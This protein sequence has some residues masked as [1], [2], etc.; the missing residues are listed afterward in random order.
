MTKQLFDR[1]PEHQPILWST[2]RHEDWP[3]ARKIISALTIC[4][5]AVA[6][7]ISGTALGRF[8]FAWSDL[9]AQFTAPALILTAILAPILLLLRLKTAFGVAVVTAAALSAAVWPQWMVD[10]GRPLVGAPVITLYSANLHLENANVSKIRSSIAQ[11]KPDIVVVVEASPTVLQELDSILVNLPNR[12]TI[13]PGIA[14]A[15]R[16]PLIPAS[17]NVRYAKLYA[18]AHI[19]SPLG[20]LNVV[21]V[22]LMRPWP[23]QAQEQ[24]I[25]GVAALEV[26][27]SQVT[28][29][30]LVAGD[31]NSVS[32]GRIGRLIQRQTGLKPNPGWPGT[33]PALAPPPFAITIDQ[34]YRTPDL[35]VLKRGLGR[36]TGSDHR[37]VVTKITESAKPGVPD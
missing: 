5:M 17:H 35:A 36:D 22:H 34:V 12:M 16:Y 4:L 29:P 25:R 9:L 14:I 15:S 27:L 24:Q 30:A 13:D 23:Y 37:P 1:G 18:L 28:G 33:W 2:R 10:R 20:P 19:D 11:A 21:G 6:L 7:L 3:V 8:D 32:S 31:F 26:L